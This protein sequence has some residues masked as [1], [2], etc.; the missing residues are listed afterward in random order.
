M[1]SEQGATRR[2]LI[3]GLQLQLA[4]ALSAGWS[5]NHARRSQ[6]TGWGST[7]DEKGWTRCAKRSKHMQHQAGRALLVHQTFFSLRPPAPKAGEPPTVDRKAYAAWLLPISQSN[8]ALGPALGT[9]AAARIFVERRAGSRRSAWI[10]R[11]PRGTSRSP[12]AAGD[13][14]NEKSAEPAYQLRKP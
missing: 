12:A 5:G 7:P 10:Q 1:R 9:A 3:C 11:P 8:R 6:F 14:A 4:H 13:R 2:N